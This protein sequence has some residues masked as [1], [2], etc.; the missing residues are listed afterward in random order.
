M[1]LGA[2]HR[3]SMFGC[4]ALAALG[5]FSGSSLLATGATLLILAMFVTSG[6]LHDERRSPLRVWMV[7]GIT[8]AVLIWAL[9]VAK[10]ARIDSVVI[11]VFLGLFNRFVLRQGLRDDLILLGGAAVLLAVST[12]ITPGLAF[13]PLF[14]GFVG[15]SYGALRSAQILGLAETEPDGRRPAVRR[16]LLERPAPGGQGRIVAAAMVFIFLGYLGLSLSPKK[17][18]ARLLGAGAFMSLPGAS[19]SMSL[20]N[21]GVGAGQ[22]GTVVLRVSRARGGEARLSG[23]YA[24]L[25]SLDAFDG[26]TWRHEQ[27]KAIWPLLGR[28]VM[29]PDPNSRD[30]VQVVLHR[31]RRRGRHPLASIG[32]KRPMRL[33]G[34]ERR[35]QTGVDGTW[36]LSMPGSALTQDYAVDLG[37]PSPPTILSPAARRAR[38]RRW[39]QLPDT[40]DPRVSAL[41]RRL[42]DSATTS[43]D[44]IAAVLGHFSQGYQYSL[45]PLEGES[46]DPLTRFLFEAKQGHCELYAGA[47]ATLL[48]V[49]GVPAR[50]A[51]GYYGGWWNSTSQVLEFT[52]QDAHAW[53][54]VFEPARGWIWVDATPASERARRRGKSLAWLWDIYDALEALWFSNVVDFDEKKRQDLIGRLMP[55]G[56]SKSDDAQRGVALGLSEENGLKGEAAALGGFVVVAGVLAGG[57][58]WWRRRSKTLG[59]RLR[60]VLDPDADPSLP[61]GHLVS[62]LPSPSREDA[63]EVVSAYEQWRYGAD[64]SAADPGNRRRKPPKSLVVAVEQLQKALRETRRPGSSN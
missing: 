63:G 19:D 50:V 46:D 10:S 3:W 42:T 20:T 27:P 9:L 17:A 30:R 61:L 22:D 62:A 34:V 44:K 15:I 29:P 43:A 32:W 36:Y 40:L 16:I 48:R 37:E 45:D 7:H 1:T 54:E 18:F 64:A 52:Q 14:I 8:V 28:R 35:V 5:T 4:C 47:V 6:Q 33:I 21:N 56:W 23:L 57:W 60:A 38:A 12:T 59:E 2:L 49:A 13:L 11:V 26:Q 53:V 51:T 58:F 25:Y 24:K 41:G 55:S 31:V 39:L